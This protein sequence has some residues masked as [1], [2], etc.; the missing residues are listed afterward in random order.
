M[1]ALARLDDHCERAVAG[2]KPSVAWQSSRR[3]LEIGPGPGVNV[4]YYP[5]GIDWFG[6]ESDL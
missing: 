5:P 6:I 1:W 4:G 3:I 2:R